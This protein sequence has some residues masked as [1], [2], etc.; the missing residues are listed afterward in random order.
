MYEE[1]GTGIGFLKTTKARNAE[2][3][4][5]HSEGLVTV[6]RLTQAD[7]KPA[8]DALAIARQFFDAHQYSKAVQAAKRAESIAITLDERFNGY[9]KAVTTLQSRIHSMRRI[10]LAT[11]AVEAVLGRAEEKVLS[12]IWENGAFVPNYLE[13]CGLLDRAEQEGRDFQERAEI[14]SNR[15]F[16]AE[17]ALEALANVSGGTNDD[18]AGHAAASALEDSLHDSTRELALGNAEGAAEI[19]KDLETKATRLRTLFLDATKTLDE[20]DTSLADLRAEGVLTQSL[21]SQMKLARD[22]LDRG[23]IEPAGAMAARLHGDTKT[24]GDLYRKATTTLGDAQILYSRLQR[25]GFHSY[26]AD[27]AM[28][29]ARRAIRE[30]SYSRAVEHL[31]RALQAFARRT[32]VRAALAKAIEDTRTRV[33]LL[34]GSGLAFMPDIQ[35]VL[36]RAEREFH[37]GNYSGS[38]ED[39]RIA[40]VLLDEVTR[41][42]SKKG[43][44]GL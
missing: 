23:L 24:I 3:A 19:A 6:L 14:A 25:E 37:G 10:G 36:G 22:M 41:A 26:E 27:A 31:E 16:M 13:A 5:G 1:K 33:R 21:E 18:V 20:T 39:L 40:T 34:Q 35:E 15:I 30:G 42:P 38:S 8:E 29:D 17:L 4:I 7:L 44:G 9:Q 11:E 32:N 12:G 28:R 2:E 43:S